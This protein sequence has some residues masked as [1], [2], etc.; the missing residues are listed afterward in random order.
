MLHRLKKMIL[1]VTH[2]FLF[3]TVFELN[4][5]CKNSISLAFGIKWHFDKLFMS[6]GA[7][8]LPHKCLSAKFCISMFLLSSYLFTSTAFHHAIYCVLKYSPYCLLLSTDPE[9]LFI[10]LY[11][12]H[13]YLPSWFEVEKVAW[14]PCLSFSWCPNRILL[15]AKSLASWNVLQFHKV[16]IFCA[17]PYLG[18][19]DPRVHLLI[20]RLAS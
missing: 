7:L 17:L 8:G 6:C 9:C 10:Q 5:W 15:S 2:Y 1:E 12:F 4:G 20:K 16:E 19:K 3:F 14:L 18:E 11:F 13:S